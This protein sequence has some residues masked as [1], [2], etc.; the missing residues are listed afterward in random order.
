MLEVALVGTGATPTISLENQGFLYFSPTCKNNFMTHEYEIVNLSRGRLNY[1]WKI[2]FECRKLLAVDEVSGTLEPHEVKKSMWRFSPDKVDKYNMTCILV[3]W[4][5]AD[6]KDAQ[7]SK[8]RALAECTHGSLQSADMYVD[9]GSVIVGSSVS[10]EITVINNNDCPLDYELFVKQTSD[11]DRT[12]NELCVLEIEEPV[13]HVEARSRQ[14]V[15]CRLRPTKLISYQF[16]VEYRIIYPNEAEA[17]RNDKRPVSADQNP[18]TPRD[19]KE[20]LCYM[21]ANGVYPKMKIKDIKCIGSASTLSQDYFWKLLSIDHFNTALN[22]EPNSDELV[23]SIATRQEANRRQCS[24]N[25]KVIIEMNFGA[26]PIKSEDTKIIFFVENVGTVPSEW[27]LLYPKDLLIEL[28]YWAQNGDYDLD[29]LE[30]MKVQ[31]N[32]LFSIEPKKGFLDPGQ[33][34]QIHVTYKH[35]FAG[36]NKLPVLFKMLKGREI[37]LNM[38]GTTVA[39]N[40]PNIHFPNS[41]YEFE[42]I[43]IGLSE[44]PIQI[45]EIYNGG[46]VA[47]DVEIDASA[48]DNLNAE[49]YSRA[50][51]KYLTEN[52][53][54]IQPGSLFETKWIFS[55]IEAKTYTAD[56]KFLVNGKDMSV[57]TLKCIG[58]DKKSLNN[59]TIASKMHEESKINSRL[60]PNQLA[61]LSMDRIS[62]GDIPLFTRE[63]KMFFIKNNSSK[64]RITF[65]WHVTNPEHGKFIRIQPAKGAIETGQNKMCKVTFMSVGKPSF[66]N[67]DLICEVKND[68]DQAVYRKELEAW[69]REQ[70]RQFEEFIIDNDELENRLNGSPRTPEVTKDKKNSSLSIHRFKTIPPIM[71]NMSIEESHVDKVRRERAEK[72]VWK[73]PLPPTPYLMHLNIIARTQYIEEFLSSKN[74]VKNEC[75]KFFDA[76]LGNLLDGVPA[77]A[78]AAEEIKTIRTTKEEKESLDF[79]MSDLIK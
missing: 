65:T 48:L 39:H 22:N 14:I 69:Q 50:I 6:K 52:K 43:E 33:S 38:V 42:P 31:D 37:L 7:L 41:L 57:V 19:V 56:I 8:L 35:I 30:E 47:C 11:E 25:S 68:S 71:K 60:L 46:N 5:E 59:M 15:R 32:K 16:T 4:I 74:T 12:C 70:T 73:K 63:R 10:Q 76:S 36:V 23:Y 45:Y 18:D 67:I 61:S 62:L 17:D 34:V 2:P 66:Y 79:I 3:S 13:G 1:E 29:E 26:A 77:G 55:P 72:K 24:N 75:V 27:A 49:N 9:F 54:Q 20:L 53:I 40:E 21:T 58:Y 51:L 64:N 28:E 78:E 44:Y